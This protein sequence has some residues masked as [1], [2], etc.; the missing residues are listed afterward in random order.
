MLIHGGRP[1]PFVRKVLTVLEEKNMSYEQ[2]DLTPFPKTP[3]LLEMSP[4]GTIPILEHD[5]AFIPDSSVICA[6]AERLEPEPAVYPKDAKDYARALF[7]EEFADT[8]FSGAVGPVFFQRFVRPHIFQQEPDEKVVQEA[9]TEALPPVLDYLETQIGEGGTF[10]DSFSIADA[11][12]AA[13][14]GSLNMVGEPVDAK[15][16]PKLASYSTALLSRPSVV[17]ASGS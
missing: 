6:Y 11:S 1:S 4:A 7:L 9:L 5:G 16:W 12:L 14:L 13:H 8:K 17:A 15:R 10:L 2:K 3:E